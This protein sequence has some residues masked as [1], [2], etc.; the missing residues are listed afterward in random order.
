VGAAVGTA[1]LVALERYRAPLR[2]WFLSEPERLAYRLKLAFLLASVAMSAPRFG[3]AVHVWRLGNNVIR[4][5]HVR[6][7]RD[8]VDGDTPIRQERRARTRGRGVK[9]LATFLA[10]VAAVVWCLLWQLA[11]A[12]TERVG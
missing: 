6:P 4:A 5:Q 3:F 12:I 8:R 7:S 11:S 9:I 2:E 1:L 10:V